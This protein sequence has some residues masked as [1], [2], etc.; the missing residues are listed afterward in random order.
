ML[1]PGTH[2]A[3]F[4]AVGRGAGECLGHKD[5]QSLCVPF[6]A[7]VKSTIYVPLDRNATRLTVTCTI[8]GGV[9]SSHLGKIARVAARASREP[10]V[11]SNVVRACARQTCVD[12]LPNPRVASKTKMA[13]RNMDIPPCRPTLYAALLPP[14]SASPCGMARAN[15]RPHRLGVT[16]S[17]QE[18]ECCWD[19]RLPFWYWPVST[20]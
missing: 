11:C 7:E 12:Y 14:V 16:S 19:A 15:T 13:V 1:A 18:S 20:A 9:G 3:V 4:A 17:S 8:G 5:T 10:F 2:D 6:V